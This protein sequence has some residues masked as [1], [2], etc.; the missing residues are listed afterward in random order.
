MKKVNK[1]K[2]NDDKSKKIITEQHNA[3][4]IKVRSA[5]IMK[6]IFSLLNEKKKLNILYYNITWQQTK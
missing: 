6:Q 1:D 4:I 2:D 5:Y 3:N